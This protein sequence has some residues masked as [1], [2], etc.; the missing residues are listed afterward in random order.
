LIIVEGDEFAEYV[1]KI[2]SPVKYDR[3][4]EERMVSFEPDEKHIILIK[5]RKPIKYKYQP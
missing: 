5:F 3:S 2:S 1:D 4:E